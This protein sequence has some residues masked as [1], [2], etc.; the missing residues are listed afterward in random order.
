ME[1]QTEHKAALA[2]GSGLTGTH[3]ASHHVTRQLEVSLGT[4]VQATHAFAR[5]YV[6]AL[7]RS[8]MS[9]P[10]MCQP[11]SMPRWTKCNFFQQSHFCILGPLSYMHHQDE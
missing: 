9:Q 3:A 2:A 4:C 7:S 6:P 8:S 1:A 10:P 5:T 11:P